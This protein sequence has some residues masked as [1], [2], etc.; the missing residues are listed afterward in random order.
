MVVFSEYLNPKRKLVDE[1]VRWLMP[2]V[3][4]D[5]T[6]AKSLAHILV[7]V[8]TAQ[9]ARSLRLALAKAFAPHGVLPPRTEMA[10]RLL[11]DDT[12][13]VATEADEIATF[14]QI[15]L[16]ADLG[17]F[18]NLFPRSPAE[19]SVEWAL[20]MAE[21]MLGVSSILGERAL[22]MREVV[23]EEDAA[24]WRD[25]AKLESIL[26]AKLESKGLIARCVSRRN[27]VKRGCVLDGV[28]EIVL[29]A[30]VDVSGA[31]VEYLQNSRQRTTVLVHADESEAS[32]FDEWGRPI[33][34]FAADIT[35]LDVFPAPSAVVEA[36]EIARHFRDVSKSEAL[37]AL[38]V[39]D[40]EM[41]PELEGAFQNHFA[42]DELSLRNPSRES[43][44]RSALGRLLLCMLEL[45]DRRDYETFST[46]V[47][48]GDVARWAAGELESSPAEVARIVG[49][50]DAIQNRYLPRTM[51]D[52]IRNAEVE[53]PELAQ[54]AHKINVALEDPFAFLRSIFA[55]LVLD[56]RDG[57]SRE[58]IAAA[59]VARELRDECRG[60]HPG[61]AFRRRLYS[62]LLK[63]ATYMLE[64]T[65]PHVLATLGWLEIPWCAEDE[66]VIAGFNEGCVPEN[67]VGHPFVPDSLRS[68]LG[69]ST[70]AARAMRDS[71]IFAEA[72]R[73][74]V[75]GAVDVH[76]HQ[77]AGDKSVMKP[78]RILFDGIGNRDLPRLA[79]RL[80]AVMKGGEGAPQKEL[81]AAWRLKLPFPPKGLVWR[82]KIAATRLDNYMRCP[83]EFFLEETFGEHS[84]D[85]SK[86]LDDMAFGTLCHGALEEFAKS[87]VKDSCD[88]REIG[89]F[90]EG[91]VRRRLMVFGDSL[92]VVIALQGEAAVARLRAFAAIQAKRRKD[93]W[94]I[95]ASERSMT[96]RFKDCPTIITAKVDRIDEHESTGELAIIDY[97]TW[98]RMSDSHKDDI[99]LP[100]YRAMVEASGRFDAA[101]ARM[102]KTLY[103]VLAERAEDTIFC[104][105]QF[106]QAEK[107]TEI[108]KALTNLA[109][110]IF[111]P[112]TAKSYWQD[113]FGPLVWESPEQ[114]VDPAWLADQSE[115]SRS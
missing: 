2:R 106:D 101:R 94:R 8:P 40:A 20:A 52:V 63:R 23:A 25:M 113:D 7:V 71:F 10:S 67:I 9:S 72:T 39:C 89:D 17:E 110:G 43:F 3:R 35:P 15:L 90:L 83:F 28:E 16:D 74:R 56:E 21:S 62:R 88:E 77:L 31:L 105:L 5:E 59:K 86:E 64:P 53:A 92:P 26:L 65:V 75:A 34:M 81:P 58:L 115:R 60:C 76:L 41:Y 19:H 114:G 112:P 57:S 66:L 84:D 93:G 80:Y 54:L 14:A 50:L 18:A 48:M 100:V 73:C 27:A 1:T 29:P 96:C 44:V 47:R 103:C 102:A 11:V 79:K 33:A 70:N 61:K 12:A 78:S 49:Q 109:K 4:T 55:S 13:S 99:Q 22:L 30:A 107:E 32:K 38:A 82:E 45:A 98:G 68:K 104:E 85:A 42:E 69:I 51:D 97:K 91:A 46:F 37:P 36:D 6:G 111:Y 108:V 87:A 95:V 24:R